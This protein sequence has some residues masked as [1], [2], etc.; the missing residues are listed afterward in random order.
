MN[1]TIEA[2][3]T[4]RSCRAFSDRQVEDEKLT[5]ILE[6]GRYAPCGRGGQPVHFVVIQDA[7]VRER[8]SHMNAEIM[9]T[10]IDPF[11]GAPTIV[12]VLVDDVPT[13]V[14]DGSLA[15][16]NMMNAAHALGVDSIWIHRAYEEFSSEE[17]RALLAE[18]GLPADGSLRGVGHCALGYAAKPLAEAAARKDNVVYVR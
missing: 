10:G 4:R 11:Y 16:G 3:A 7:A 2:L 8:L 15:L 1:E 14:E 18:W 13:G 9:G 6:T 5:Q 12:A 17:G